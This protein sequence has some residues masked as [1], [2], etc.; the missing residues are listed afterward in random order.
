MTISELFDDIDFWVDSNTTSYPLADKVRGINEWQGRVNSSIWETT[1]GWEY[2]DS[3]KETLPIGEA[4]LVAGQKDYTLPS[5]AQRLTAASVKDAAGTW[6]PLIPI[7]VSDLN[8]DLEEL[9]SKDGLPRY[10]DLMGSSLILRPAPSSSATTL[11]GGLR[12][13]LSREGDDFETTDTDS[14]PGFNKN[15]HRILSVGPSYDY[16]V[17]HNM[18]EKIG[19][20]KTMLDEMFFGLQEFY[21]GRHREETA[22]IKV[23]ASNTI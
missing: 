16:A 15:F 10:Y 12:V 11:S 17:A 23:K 13:Y 21:G 8:V 1:V 22:R 3:N 20:L 14:T 18:S 5:T 2:D 4:N 6:V 7:D 19:D 9:E